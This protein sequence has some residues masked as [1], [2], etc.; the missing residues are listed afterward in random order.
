MLADEGVVKGAQARSNTAA[1][2]NACISWCAAPPSPPP[3]TAP[4]EVGSWG[5]STALKNNKPKNN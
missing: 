5:I 2:H 1:T 3:S 4:D